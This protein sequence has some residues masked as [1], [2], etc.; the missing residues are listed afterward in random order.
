MA[1]HRQGNDATFDYLALMQDSAAITAS[2]VGKVASVAKI[3]D[4]GQGRMDA[5]LILDSTAVEVAT[6][7]E[8]YIVLVQGSSSSTCAT[9]VWNLGAMV[10]GDSSVSLETV[11]SVIGRREIAFCNEVNGTTYRYLRVYFLLAGTTNDSTGLTCSAYLV[12]QA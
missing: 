7:N 11:D 2:V 9:D 10:V 3:F 12:K 4:A 1:L 8:Q 6:G 5:R